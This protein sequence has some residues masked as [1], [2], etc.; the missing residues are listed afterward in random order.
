MV[1]LC[2]AL[3]MASLWL[4]IATWAGWVIEHVEYANPGAERTKTVQ[5]ISKNRLKAVSEG[6]MFI[7][8]FPQDSFTATD[9]ENRVY[10]SGTVQEYVQEVQKFQQAAMGLARQQMQDAMQEM[11]PEQRKG[12][13]DLLKQLANPAAPSPPQP[14]D[15]RPRVTVERTQENATIA[16]YK[17]T[18]ALVYSDGKPYQEVW[19]AKSLDLKGDLDLKRMR[20]LQAKLT[21]AI[22]PETSSS[23]AVE[24][25]PL[26]EKIFDEGYPV[27]I[28]EFGEGGE[29]ESITEVAQVEKRDLSDKEFQPPEGYRRIDLRQ[30]FGEELEKMKRG[31]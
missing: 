3:W 6:S 17:A 5:Y 14:P 28:V 4:P 23:Q 7:M 18:K 16:G 19:L 22:L 21:K 12:M 8:H 1:R 20:S 31:E 9:Q 29:P 13:E 27:K 30:F 11:S 15:K 26:Y 10:W 2:I 25:D 24:D